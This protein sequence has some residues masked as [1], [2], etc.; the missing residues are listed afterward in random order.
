MAGESSTAAPSR[1]EQLR[2]FL[3]IRRAQITPADVGLAD[4]GRRRTP[5]LRR[6]EL[7]MLAGVGVSWYTWLEQGREINVSPEVLNAISRVLRL[8]EPEKA[9]LYVLAGLNPPPPNGKN[10]NAVS[11][12]LRQLI[13]SW[14]P[15]PAVLQDRY[16]NLPAINDAAKL[17]FGYTD[18]DTNCFV[19]FFTNPRYRTMHTHWATVAPQVVAAYRRDAARFPD[20]LEF[21]RVID[22]LSAVSPEFVDLWSRHEVDSHVQAV[23]AVEHPD[24]GELVFDTTTLDV[25]DRPDL[26][27]V[28]Y[29]PRPGTHTQARIE[30]LVGLTWWCW[31]LDK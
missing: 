11:P 29:N 22:Q 21:A 16:W 28:L 1:R 18:T 10:D 13:D 3:R 30:R 15:R 7:A 23:K 20:D 4:V 8:S 9:H 14:N 19:A 2:D 12:E 31:S 17:V 5:G 24:A 27:L 6:E 26:S 25:S